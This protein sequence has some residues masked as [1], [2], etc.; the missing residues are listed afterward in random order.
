MKT[1]YNTNYAAKKAPL[2]L[3]AFVIGGGVVTSPQAQSAVV[4]VY[5]YHH[6]SSTLLY[7]R[8]PGI[9]DAS[10]GD[11]GFNIADDEVTR[12][13]TILNSGFITGSA[14]RA[15][16]LDISEDLE[17]NWTNAALQAVGGATGR[18]LALDSNDTTQTLGYNP[19]TVTVNAGYQ[20]N[21]AFAG[22]NDI[23]AMSS[24]GALFLDED[25]T[26]SFY[27]HING[28]LAADYTWSALSGAGG[29]LSGAT[30]D[31]SLIQN[32]FIGSEDDNLGFLVG[33]DVIEY[34]HQASGVFLRSVDYST[35]TDGP[36]GQYT[37]ADIID[38][39]A[40]GNRFIGLDVGPMIIGVPEPSVALLSTLIGLGALLRRRRL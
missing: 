19:A 17:F 6:A 26:L 30:L 34:Y 39:G 11:S 2:S 38:N 37:L 4:E 20:A 32:N 23:I 15:R 5:R 10:Y 3:I 29:T 27:N 21:V 18:W 1:N 7:A 28:G 31:L 9:S 14:S 8:T 25:N 12:V 13:S 22:N 16:G 24:E 36:L 35:A 33:D 40:G